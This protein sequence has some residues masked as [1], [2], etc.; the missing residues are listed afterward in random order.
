VLA[1]GLAGPLLARIRWIPLVAGRVVGG[2]AA[3]RALTAVAVVT[4]GLLALHQTAFLLIAREHRERYVDVDGVVSLAGPSTPI[5]LWSVLLAAA[6]GV[7]VTAVVLAPFVRWWTGRWPDR[8]VGLALSATVALG[9]VVRVVAWIRILP[10]RTD[11]G[12][13][14]F[15]HVTANLLAEGRGFPEPLNWIDGAREIPSALHGPLYPVV[16]SIASRLGGRSYVDHK[17][18]SILIGTATVLVVVLLARRLAGNRAALAAGALAAVYPNLWMIDGLLFPEGL[19]ALLTTTAVLVAYQW[20]DHPALWRAAILG[21]LIG[22]AGLTRGEGLL[23]GVLVAMPWMLMTRS[24]SLADRWKHL[25]LAGA[26]CVVVLA[27]WTV[28]NLGQF[29][30]LVPLSTNGNELLVYANCDRVYEGRLLGHWSFQ[31]QEDHRTEF[32]EPPGDESEKARY[33][34]E[35]GIDYVR[36]HMD[37]LPA[38]MAARV[39]RTFE[40]YRPLQN[41]E[42]VTLEGR[43]KNASTAGLLMYGGLVVGSIAGAVMLRRRG[44]PLLPIGAQFVSVAL[45]AVYAYGTTRFRAPVEPMLCVLAGV[46]AVPA[47]AWVRRRVAPPPV[48]PA[49][50]PTHDTI[51][52]VTGGSGGL[53]RRELGAWRTWAALGVVAVAVALPLGGLFRTTGGTMEEGFMLL[54]PE[55]MWQGDVPNVDFLHLYGPGALHVLMVW[56]KVFGSTLEAERAFGL[57]QHVGII[58]GLF[59]LARPWGRAA[60]ATVATSSVFLV[61]TP[62]GLTAMAWNGGLALSLWAVI[63]AVRAIHLEDARAR[64]VHFA[65]AGAVAAFGLTFRPDLVVALGLVGAVVLWCHRSAW[66]PLLLGAL[67]GATPMWVHLA[68]AGLGPSIQGM[69]LDPVFELRPGRELPRPPSW[70]RLDGSLQAIAETVPPWWGLPHLTASAS[71]WMWF[72]VL[73][74]VA[75]GLVVFAAWRFRASGRSPRT[76]ALL[77]GALI[78]VGIVPQAL[79]RPDSTHLAWVTCISWP[80]LVLAVW[81]VLQL[82]RPATHPRTRVAVGAMV[83]GG[84]M[85]VVAPLFTYRYYLQPVRVAVGDLPTAFPV[86]RDGRRFYL[87][88]VPPFRATRDVVATLDELA[89]PGERLFVGPQDLRRTWYNDTFFYWMFPELDPATFFTEMDPG[90]AN[91]PGS[92]LADDVAS[93]D[94]LI[95]TGFWNGWREPN[96]SMDFGSDAP[97]QVVRDQFCLVESFEDGLVDLYRRC[98]A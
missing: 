80:L 21:A 10:E 40:L 77:G 18:T 45:T 53:R 7:L 79:Q 61:L 43:P 54:F 94:W 22:L 48:D 95:L 47:T 56:F 75:V 84:L 9:F 58:L 98:D 2:G 31:C 42:L 35:V 5:V 20:R 68:I 57:L 49:V 4:P 74:L 41:V 16:L 76:W 33:W 60:A 39:G 51:S 64:W 72:W 73:L 82:R 11:G 90:I 66:K 34:R 70:D 32:G 78:G 23:L 83:V 97:N 24:L 46:A 3:G 93:A 67:V 92:R 65:A 44:V 37:R 62:I 96:T 19:F 13:P 52:Y 14:L 87:G 55:R 50:I 1:A 25:V 28:R 27:P 69:V 29:D 8:T 12:D 59:T 6:L 26:T 85:F 63:L 71:L 81:E 88:D 17:V 86:E 36:D 38:V 89:E 15:Y 30:E 91:A